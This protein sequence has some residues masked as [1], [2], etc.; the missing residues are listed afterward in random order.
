MRSAMARLVAGAFLG[1]LAQCFTS[2]R[3]SRTL[4]RASREELLLSGEGAKLM[5]QLPAVK[6]ED[7]APGAI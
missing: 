2:G 3:Q 5:T 6:Q 7:M 4:R 1:L